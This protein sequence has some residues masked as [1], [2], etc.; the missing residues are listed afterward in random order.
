[1]QTDGQTKR[2]N[3][4]KKA[5]LQVFV[6]FEQNNLTRFLLIVEFAYNNTKNAST[7][8]PPFEL[9]C[10]YYLCVFLKKT[11]IFAPNQK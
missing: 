11:P 4:I 1:M 9:N 7:S 5:Y 3:S 6:N 10:S 8:Y 2:Q